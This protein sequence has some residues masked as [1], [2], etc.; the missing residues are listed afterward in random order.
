[1]FIYMI[2]IYIYDIGGS[3]LFNFYGIY[4]YNICMLIWKSPW[5]KYVYIKQLP[6][7]GHLLQAMR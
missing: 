6:S 7:A 4:I 3:F 1:M 2:Y 5:F